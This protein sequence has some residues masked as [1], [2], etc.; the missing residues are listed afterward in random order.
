MTITFTEH[1]PIESGFSAVF[2]DR[3]APRLTEFDET[4]QAIL[5]VVKQHAAIA[6]GVGAVFGLWLWF[7]GSGSKDL[8]E[9][10]ATW[11]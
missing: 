9:L 8:G 4:R 6:L 2:N 5:V 1:A 11:V 3:I 7:S 10:L